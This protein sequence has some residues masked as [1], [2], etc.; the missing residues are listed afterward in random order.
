MRNP[1]LPDHN[2][3]VFILNTQISAHLSDSSLTIS[4]LLRL[5]G[6]SRTD[7]HRKIKR[8]FGMSAGRYLRHVR[9]QRAA[10]LLEE[11]P[12]WTLYQIALEV[13]FESQ[14]YFSRAFKASYGICPSEYRN[15][16]YQAPDTAEVMK[17]AR[18][19]GRKPGV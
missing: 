15:T 18:Q 12:E 9:L 14:S 5:V 6:M 11:H 17:Y 7:L 19:A 3:F 1:H 8:V 2:N 13:G 10:T 4:R 16:V